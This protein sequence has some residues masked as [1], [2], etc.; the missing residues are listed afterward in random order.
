MAIAQNIIDLANEEDASLD[1]VAALLEKNVGTNQIKQWLL[2]E[3][4]LDGVA[5]LHDQGIDSHVVTQLID[6]KAD[7]RDIAANSQILLDG[8][9]RVDL[10]S[11]WL[12]NGTHLNDA[13]AIMSQGVDLNLIG[14]SSEGGDFT[15]LTGTPPNHIISRIPRMQRTTLEPGRITKGMN[16]SGQMRVDKIGR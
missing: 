6:N 9:V 10:I 5:T 2:D 11:G 7:L 1:D 13:I 16:L 8:G 3:V 4:E 15:G 12:K 14:T